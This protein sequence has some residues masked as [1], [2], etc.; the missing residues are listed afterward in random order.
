MKIYKPLSI[1]LLL[2]LGLGVGINANATVR[3]VYL[4][5]AVTA[6]EGGIPDLPAGMQQKNL[7][8]KLPGK[9]NWGQHRDESLRHKLP[10][11]MSSGHLRRE[12]QGKCKYCIGPARRVNPVGVVNP[13]GPNKPVLGSWGAPKVPNKVLAPKGFDGYYVPDMS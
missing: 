6:K 8:S 7:R 2:M 9:M 13:G 4:K 1:S 10:G 12:K 3:H 11:K 5:E